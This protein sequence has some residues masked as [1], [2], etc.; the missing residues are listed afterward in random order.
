MPDQSP[1]SI[2]GNEQSQHYQLF[3]KIA[4][5]IRSGCELTARESTTEE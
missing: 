2:D 1:G 4:I 3:G 5:P